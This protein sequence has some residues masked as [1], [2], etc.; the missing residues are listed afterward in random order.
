M[1]SGKGSELYLMPPQHAPFPVAGPN[2]F[3]TP[4]RGPVSLGFTRRFGLGLSA[5]ADRRR[6]RMAHLVNQVWI[7]TS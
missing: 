3:A 6:A 5:P 1:A 2:R 7:W 4:V